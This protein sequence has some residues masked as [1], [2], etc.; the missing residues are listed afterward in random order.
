[1]LVLVIL[2]ILGTA[3]LTM[4]NTELLI[5]RNMKL[6]SKAFYMAEAGAEHAYANFTCSN[7]TQVFL[8]SDY[9]WWNNGN[10]EYNASVIFEE[11]LNG[12]K[13]FEKNLYFID[14]SGRYKNALKHISLKVTHV[15]PPTTNVDGALG[16]YAEN[17]DAL[18]DAGAQGNVIISGKD[19]DPPADFECIGCSPSISTL[20]FKTHSIYTSTQ[21][22]T[23]NTVGNTSLEP[24]PGSVDDD[25]LD[26]PEY[27]F[28][29]W[30][31]YVQ[32]LED[33]G[34]TSHYSGDEDEINL[35]TR[36]NPKI[37]VLEAGCALGGGIFGA[38]ILVVKGD[39]KITG[40][41]RFDGLVIVL[42]EGNED[43]EFFSS[44]TPNIY[45]SVIVA[46]EGDIDVNISGT[47]DIYYS[48]KA[49]QNINK[50]KNL[51]SK[52]TWSDQT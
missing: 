1:V 8:S 48:S 10:G 45:G 34:L 6:N 37:S 43:I 30:K 31:L 22:A 28:E 29:D 32:L 41:F 25:S 14:S 13:I 7:Q 35:G 3:A 46:G 39:A 50:M 5:A 23:I 19:N 17:T 40:N 11:P 33:E 38:G 42:Q 2:S 16:I 47:V 51:K 4:T 24:E 9:Q 21:N 49:I 27:A 26:T 36:D 15:V 20:D 52:I 18:I 12:G 44:G